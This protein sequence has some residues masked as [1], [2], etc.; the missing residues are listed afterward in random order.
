MHEW[1]KWSVGGY[2]EGGKDKVGHVQIDTASHVGKIR[3]FEPDAEKI[4]EQI[5]RD[6]NAHSKLKASVKAMLLIV[7]STYLDEVAA[8]NPI[9]AQVCFEA[10]EQARALLVELEGVELNETH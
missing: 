7:E 10:Q 3:V 6:H 4:A 1:Q 5:V 9:A 8:N 2:R